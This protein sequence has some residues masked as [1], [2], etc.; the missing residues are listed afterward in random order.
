MVQYISLYLTIGLI[1]SLILLVS[2]DYTKDKEVKDLVKLMR[3]SSGD[4]RKD[5]SLITLLI[6]SFWLPILI[7]FLA[8]EVSN[9]NKKE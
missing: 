1:F 5:Y 7:L 8:N 6:T 4:I 3:D 9:S 2:I